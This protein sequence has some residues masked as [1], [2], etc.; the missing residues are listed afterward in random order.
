MKYSRGQFNSEYYRLWEMGLLLPIPINASVYSV[1]YRKNN[2]DIYSR[3]T[4]KA[5]SVSDALERACYAVTYAAS[6][7][8]EDI[9]LHAVYDIEENL[10]WIDEPYYDVVQTKNEF[11]GMER[12]DFLAKFG[13]TSAAIL[14]GVYPALVK[15]ATTTVNFGGSASGFHPTG[16]Q[17]Y[18]NPGSYNWTVPASVTSVSVV[19]VGGGGAGSGNG[20][21]NRGGGGGGLS[22]KNGVAVSPGGVHSVAVGAGGLGINSGTG[23]SR[24]D[25]ESS[26][27]LGLSAT[28]GLA[29]WGSGGSVNRPTGSGGVGSGGTG[30]YSGGIAY[31][32]NAGGGGGA[33]GYSGNGG[34][35][36]TGDYTGSAQAG[37]G[38][39]G[40]GGGSGYTG[41]G[42]GGGVGLFGQ[43]SVGAGGVNGGSSTTGGGGGSGGTGGAFNDGYNGGGGGNYGGGGGGM[44]WGSTG[45]NGGGGA[46]RII[47][48]PGRSF[49]S[50]A[51]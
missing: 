19:C 37:S 12:R 26:G 41:G 45:G 7:R 51:S 47:W 33:A 38:G 31:A 5:R 21:G 34:N 32:G 28:G 44:H 35:N 2:F 6:W 16:E 22:W 18:T 23:G 8:P 49:P 20:Y 25:G 13:A 43:G 39:G 30:N 3:V 36:A 1:K 40:G 48:G 11:R 9:D 42:G 4:L 29:V 15:A 14:F 17:L 50:N 10:L 27:V 24:P 46:V